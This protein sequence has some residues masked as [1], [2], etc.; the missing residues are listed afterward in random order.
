[1]IIIITKNANKTKYVEE[2]SINTIQCCVVPSHTRVSRT[3]TLTCNGLLEPRNDRCP[4]TVAARGLS[5][6][7]SPAGL[8]VPPSESADRPASAS[9]GAGEPATTTANDGSNSDPAV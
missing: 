6:S 3:V 1:M 4:L 8:A 2:K 9:A 5:P 7:A